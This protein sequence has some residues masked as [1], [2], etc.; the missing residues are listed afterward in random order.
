MNPSVFPIT[1]ANWNQMRYLLLPELG[2]AYFTVTLGRE[3]DNFDWKAEGD[4][5]LLENLKSL[6]LIIYAANFSDVP[7]QSNKQE[8]DFGEVYLGQTVRVKGEFIEIDGFWGSGKGKSYDITTEG[9]QLQ[10]N[11]E[12]SPCCEKFSLGV[13]EKF[14][15]H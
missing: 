14:S 2:E 10:R 9:S 4:K 13:V 8:I 15:A 7:P 12:T 1:V 6:G 5:I 3:S 11:T